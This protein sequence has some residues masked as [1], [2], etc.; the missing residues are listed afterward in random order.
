MISRRA[1]LVPAPPGAPDW[2]ERLFLDARKDWRLAPGLSV[3]YSGRLNL[4]A[5]DTLP[6]PTHENVR[7]D[8]RE[9]Y[10]SWTPAPQLFLEAGRI[11]LK[12]GVAAGYNPTDFFKTRA[13]VEPLTSDPQALREDRLGTAML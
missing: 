10:A 13:V 1:V 11:N 4:R 9:G 5:E 2:E 8:F 3:T 12:S 6:I 7:H